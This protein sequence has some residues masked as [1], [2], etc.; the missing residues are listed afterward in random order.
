MIGSWDWDW[1]WEIIREQ[2]NE[3]TE[4]YVEKDDD[5]KDYL[6]GLISFT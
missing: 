2:L 3:T 1:V 5:F 4:L 6:F